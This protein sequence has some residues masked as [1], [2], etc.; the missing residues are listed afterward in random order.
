MK[1]DKNSIAKRKKFHFDNIYMDNPQLYESIILYQ[2]GDLSCEGG[3]DLGRH[4]QYC[5]EISFIA[6][7]KG[8]FY[9][10]NNEYNI[11]KGDIYLSLPDEFHNGRADF[12]DPFR[13]FYVG[14]NFAENLNDSNS[15]FHIKRL[16][17]QISNPVIKDKLDIQT[18]FI[19]IFNELINLNDFSNIMIKTYLHQIVILAY[20]SFSELWEKEYSQDNHSEKSKKI[21]YEIVNYI[22]SNLDKI[23]ELSN[24]ADIFGYSYSHLSRIFS[25][26]TGSSIQEYYN[27]KRF[28]KAVQWLKQSNLSITE[29]AE[30]LN[31]QSIHSFSK[32]FRKSF[33][34]SP[35]QYQL[36]CKRDI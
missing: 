13:Y 5:Y 14:F 17:D 1:I 35:T 36:L 34:I 33:G 28:E 26:E 29:I 25:S 9:S 20:R 32:A 23:I 12:I 19:N 8:V 6:S 18:P 22:D 16:F 4:K 10:N 11:K 2:I 27:K 15:F 7:G 3:F 30:N 31:Y 21:V 24:I